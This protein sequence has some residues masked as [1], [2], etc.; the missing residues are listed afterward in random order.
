LIVDEVFLSD[1]RHTV[2]HLV[3]QQYRRTHKCGLRFR[4][5]WSL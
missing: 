3:C 1:N 5:Q 4:R 2:R